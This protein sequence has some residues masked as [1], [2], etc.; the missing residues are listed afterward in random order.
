LINRLILLNSTTPASLLLRLRPIGLALRGS[1]FPSSTEEG[2]LLPNPIYSHLYR[3]PPQLAS[4]ELQ[5][6]LPRK[7]RGFSV[8]PWPRIV[9]KRVV[10]L[11]IDLVL[12]LFSGRIHHLFRPERVA[13]NPRV[14]LGIV[15]QYRRLNLFETDIRARSV[16]NDRFI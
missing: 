14:R 5:C 16:K 6:P 12:K 13:G 15:R 8:V 1:A 7:L 3:P 10:G 4:Q 11:W 2:S 9:E